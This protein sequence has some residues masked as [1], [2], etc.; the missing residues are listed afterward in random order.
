M[1]LFLLLIFP[2][3]SIWLVSKDLFFNQILLGFKDFFLRGVLFFIPCF[4]FTAIFTSFL[5]RTYTVANIYFYY[6]FADY[7]FY[8]FFCILSCLVKFRNK[9]FVS[10][11]ER[12]N[13]YFLF[14]AGFYTVFTFYSAA[15]NFN[16]EDLYTLFLK[17]ITLLIIAAYSSVFLALKDSET[18]IIKYLY[19]FLIIVFPVIIA[20]VP[21]FFYI[22]Y[23]IF[24]FIVIFGVIVPS[25]YFYFKTR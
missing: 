3:A 25:V 2:I 24:S 19:I 8:H 12:I 1:Y 18:G 22:R 6:L 15:T 13:H 16:S 9:M 7:F 4:L 10:T 14:F 17:P 21:F 20:L 11:S 23:P 5:N